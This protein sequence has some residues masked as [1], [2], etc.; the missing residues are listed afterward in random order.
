VTLIVEDGTGKTDA[1]SYESVSGADTYLERWE[2][3]PP[4]IWFGV[5]A[6]G[7]LSIEAI[8][9]DTETVTI[10]SKV[11]TFK[12]AI[13]AADGDVAIGAS[14]AESRTNLLAAV[15]L[16]GTAGTQYGASMTI[17]P[18]VSG[19]SIEGA[20]VFFRSKTYGDVGNGIATTETLAGTGNEWGAATLTG[21]SDPTLDDEAKERHLRIATRRVDVEGEGMWKG[22]KL[23]Y[24]QALA[25]P[26]MDVYDDEG[27][28]IDYAPLPAAL[29]NSTSLFALASANGD[30]LY[31]DV[32]TS[33]AL[34]SK[35]VRIEGAVTIKKDWAEGSNPTSKAYRLAV[36]LLAPLREPGGIVWRA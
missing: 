33:G 23:I 4:A 6:T 35:T 1:E 16:S 22:K 19:L 12:T 31:P 2:D 26:K 34:K 13:T 17:H 28:W 36:A 3:P 32:S 11:Y 24:N 21:G 8:P 18:D 5:K 29:R 20:V 10:G 9:S 7:A 27:N 25:H 30:D 15:N 14:V